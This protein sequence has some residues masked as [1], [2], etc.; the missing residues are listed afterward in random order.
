MYLH[1]LDGATGFN[2]DTTRF[3]GEPWGVAIAGIPT[4]LSGT[5]S[6]IVEARIET[7]TG[8]YGTPTNA[9]RVG[10][11]QQPQVVQAFIES[12]F[13]QDTPITD[14]YA[15]YWARLD[16]NLAAKAAAAGNQYW[17]SFWAFKTPS[18]LRMK[19]EI[20]NWKAG[21]PSWVATMDN[22][23]HSASPPATEYWRQDSDQI[24]VP[25]DQWFSVEIYLHRSTGSDG[26]FYFGVNGQQV[27]NRMGPNY[28]SL[29]EPIKIIAHNIAYG[30]SNSFPGWQWVDDFEVRNVPPCAGVPC[31]PPP[32]LS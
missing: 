31:G 18:D 19:L 7:V 12:N 24:K 32:R 28:G 27:F 25:L 22:L 2:W 23:G 5:T 14:Y 15:R 6:D 16:P 21:G 20:M 26:R 13:L 3:L 1:G 10:V 4:G 9:L 17:R 30:P 11:K 8:P 29:N